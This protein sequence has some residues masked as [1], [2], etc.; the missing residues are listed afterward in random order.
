[1]SRFDSIVFD[2]DGTLWDTTH[3]C[4]VAW[5]SV[6]ERHAI[7]YRTITPDDVRRVTGKPH[8]LC[9]EETFGDL[10][11]HQIEALIAETATEDNLTI[12]R[13]G[14]RLYPFV[15]T[16]LKSLATS[17]R[18]FIVSNC[19]AGYIENFL[20][21][22]GLESLFQDFESFGN[23]GQPKGE[24]LRRVIDRNHLR[25]PLMVGDTEGDHLAARVCGVPFCL[26]TYGFG[27]SP[28]PTTS[29][30]L[31]KNSRRSSPVSSPSWS[32]SSSQLRG[33]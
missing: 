22:S 7:P 19:Q 10:A 25:S 31:S 8:D 15:E 5:N 23:T 24:N 1:L 27:H 9:I 17:H 32:G 12:E 29:A 18:L 21:Q 11:D 4:A 30:T 6:L 3:A 26:L 2:L 16:G 28:I 13:M 20:R 33:G 14:G